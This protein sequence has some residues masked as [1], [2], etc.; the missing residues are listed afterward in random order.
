MEEKSIDEIR[1]IE[2]Q[3]R[4]KNTGQA[5]KTTKMKLREYYDSEHFAQKRLTFKNTALLN[6]KKGGDTDED[7]C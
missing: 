2:E 5:Q 3:V 7:K 6:Q 4:R 1:R